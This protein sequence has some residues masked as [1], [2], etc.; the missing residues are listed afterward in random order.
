MHLAMHDIEILSTTIA[1]PWEHNHTKQLVKP[2]TS[3][4]LVTLFNGVAKFWN[5]INNN[6]IISLTAIAV[7]YLLRKAILVT[8]SI[9]TSARG[10]T[11]WHHN[12]IL[13]IAHYTRE[14]T[15][16]DVQWFYWGCVRDFG[17]VIFLSEVCIQL[18]VQTVFGFT[19]P[20]MR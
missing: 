13:D 10:L 14:Q 18:R 17:V 1:L 11:W 19:S 7:N 6:T 5:S 9:V 4:P 12:S 15:L 8:A 16:T 2:C 3:S 20:N